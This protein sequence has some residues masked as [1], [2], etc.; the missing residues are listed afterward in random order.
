MKKLLALI[1]GVIFLASC[2]GSSKHVSTAKSAK[3]SNHAKRGTQTYIPSYGEDG[4]L[5]DTLYD[6]LGHRSNSG[7]KYS[8][9]VVSD[10]KFD[11]PMTYNPYV[12]KWVDYFTGSGRGHFERYLARSGRFIPYMHVVLKKYGLPKDI[13]YLSMIESGFNI[14]ARSWAS[15]VGPWQFIRST[16]ALYGLNVDYYI[17]ERRDVEKATDAAV[18]HLK[19][20]HDEFGDWYL[21]FGAYNA[22]AGKIRN[23]INRHGTNFWDMVEGSYLRQETKDYVP[24]ILAAAI[25]AKNP[26]KYGFTRIN[27]QLP[28]D[29]EKVRLNSPIDLEVAAECAGVDADLIRLLNP[30]LL[31]DMTPPHMPGYALNIPAGTKARFNK[32]YASLSPSQRMAAKEYVVQRGESVREIANHWGVSERELAQAN[33]GSIDIDRDT[34]TRKVAVRGKRGKIK[35]RNEKVT[36]ASYSVSPGARLTIPKNRS[37]AGYASSRDDDAANGAKREF[38]INIAQ[39]EAPKKLSKK[40]Q[41]AQEKQRK[42]ELIAQAKA[43]KEQQKLA[44]KKPK[45]PAPLEPLPGATTSTATVASKKTYDDVAVEGDPF[46]KPDETAS[47]KSSDLADAGEPSAP[48]A[49]SG[50]GSIPPSGPLAM[51]DRPEGLSPASDAGSPSDAELKEAVQKLN[52]GSASDLETGSAPAAEPRW[53]EQGS[54]APSQPSAPPV[55]QAATRSKPSYYVVKKGDTLSS[56]ADRYAVSV[57][58]LK[59]WN[60]KKVAPFPKSGVKIQVGETGSP[61]PPAVLASKT[62]AKAP[63]KVASAKKPAPAQKKVLRYKVRPGDNLTTIARRHDT[64]PAAIQR[65]NGLK[66][67]KLVPGAILIVNK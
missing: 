6:S 5:E 67:A 34:V 58:E 12:Q 17:D 60:G 55:R 37:L 59:K 24:K 38:G 4:S 9:Y 18:R 52:P 29:Y 28:I 23:A 63:A 26:A 33:A 8:S 21:A 50:T 16:G 20:L 42:Q 25:V 62:P 66:G 47:E 35:Y 3:K 61:V 1:S 13:V 40:E 44:A 64:T 14:R 57:E 43:E 7:I 45:G 10:G 32:R 41:K 48:A 53:V 30:E 19:D 11:I 56:I 49:S 31:Q 2:G 39:L 27:Y 36:I 65:L 15:A 54:Q 46:A 51:N 22:G